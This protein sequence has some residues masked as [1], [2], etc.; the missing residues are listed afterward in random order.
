LR[1]ALASTTFA[2]MTD[3]Q[4]VQDSPRRQQLLAAARARFV[5]DGFANTPVSAIVR[6]AGVAQGTFYLYFDNK[7]ALITEL[8]REVVR[9]YEGTL[10]KIAAEGGPVDERL[11][12]IIVAMSAAVQRNLSLERVFREAESGES[13]LRAAREGRRRL[14]AQAAAMLAADGSLAVV[15]PERTAGFVV[16]LFDHILYEAHAY[17]PDAVDA[18]VAESLRFTLQGVGVAPQRVA[19]LVARVRGEC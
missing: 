3:N 4:S 19:E 16:T 17:E 14:A 18:V 2:D 7:Q 13:T 15:D 10:R 6:D 11:A 5:R 1:G 12:R 8:R 9:D